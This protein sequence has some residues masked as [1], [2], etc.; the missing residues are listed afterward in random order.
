[1]SA[2]TASSGEE[3]VFCGGAALNAAWLIITA[4]KARMPIAAAH[5]C[6]KST[7]RVR[8]FLP[9]RDICN[10]IIYLK[11]LILSIR[12]EPGE[13]QN[14]MIVHRQSVRTLVN[15]PLGHRPSHWLHR[16]RLARLLHRRAIH[17]RLRDST[18]CASWRCAHRRPC[19]AP[20]RHPRL[21]LRQRFVTHRRDW[22]CHPARRR[23]RRATCSRP[24]RN[25]MQ[26]RQPHR[27]TSRYLRTSASVSACCV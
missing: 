11:T 6:A 22:Q 25:P 12:H 16:R 4:T 18:H 1:M 27:L 23:C 15:I 24:T 26:R 9:Y 17:R 10:S 13:D 19:R 2:R 8:S 21:S 7:R 5:K 3:N 14:F 20:R